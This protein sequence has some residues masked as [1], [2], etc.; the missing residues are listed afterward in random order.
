MKQNLNIRRL[1]ELNHTFMKCKDIISALLKNT[2]ALVAQLDSFLLP[3][4]ASATSHENKFFT[5]NKSFLFLG[6]PAPFMGTT[7]IDQGYYKP[8]TGSLAWELNPGPT[9][10]NVQ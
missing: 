3:S 1:E 9:K 7:D 2:C 5:S 4:T 10:K 6:P 8:E